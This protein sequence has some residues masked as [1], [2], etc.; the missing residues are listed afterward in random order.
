MTVKT[1]HGTFECRDL[2]FKDRREL[3]RL[4]VQAVDNEGKFQ[5]DKYYDVIEWV[6]DFAFDN[7]EEHLSELSDVEI[8]IVLT[9]IYSAYKQ[10]PKKKK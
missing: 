8:D 1:E 3:H 7:P 5:Q 4:E 10:P 6:M 9:E 2:T